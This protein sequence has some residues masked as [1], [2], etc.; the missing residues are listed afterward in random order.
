MQRFNAKYAQPE[1]SQSNAN[2]KQHNWRWFTHAAS[3]GRTDQVGGTCF[4]FEAP[5]TVHDPLMIAKRVLGKAR[6]SR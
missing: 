1:K 3:R 5:G 4:S 2:Q 6:L